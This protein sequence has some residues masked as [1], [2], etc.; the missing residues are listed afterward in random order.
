MYLVVNTRLLGLG[1]PDMEVNLIVF[2]RLLKLNFIFYNVLVNQLPRLERTR[3]MNV[4][5]PQIMTI[6]VLLVDLIY[7]SILVEI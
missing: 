5:I 4:Q 6:T 1:L 2:L 7:I 3:V